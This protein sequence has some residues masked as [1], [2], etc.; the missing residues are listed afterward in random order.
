MLLN[1]EQSQTLTAK[2]I[3]G[4]YFMSQVTDSSCVSSPGGFTDV[5]TS[6][7]NNNFLA[8]NN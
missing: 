6:K 1:N 7:N 2:R 8:T 3:G 5:I 4:D